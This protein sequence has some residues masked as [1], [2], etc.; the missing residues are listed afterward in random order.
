MKT[1]GTPQVKNV[2]TYMG[3]LETHRDSPQDYTTDL[4]LIHFRILK[5]PD[6]RMYIRT[7]IH[8]YNP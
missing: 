7:Y 4:Y 5:V 3:Q 2:L 6:E 8:A 1:I